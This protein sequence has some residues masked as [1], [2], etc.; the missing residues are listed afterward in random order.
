LSVGGRCDKN[1]CDDYH[2]D[3]DEDVDDDCD[4]ND[5][6]ANDDDDYDDY[7]DD[8]D[9]DNDNDNAHNKKNEQGINHVR[10]PTVRRAERLALLH[11]C[12][13]PRFRGNAARACT[14]LNGEG[15][16]KEGDKTQ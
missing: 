15:L 4:D 1:D 11:Q 2:D 14:T 6:D 5:D 16:G 8:G 3:D 10:A 9:D 12:G 13:E 7:N